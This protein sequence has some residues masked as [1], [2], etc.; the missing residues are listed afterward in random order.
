MIWQAILSVFLT[1]LIGE[2]LKMLLA[3]VRGTSIRL[4]QLGGM[5]SMHT[6]AVA[7]LMLSVYFETGISMLLVITVV[8]GL[9]VIRDA[10]GL[11]W[12][13]SL[14]SIA[15]NK[16]TKR[17]EHAIVGHTFYEALAGFAL[18]VSVT[19]IVYFLL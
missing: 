6:G 19:L 1:T 11:R 9:I 3:Y 18:G 4:M 14:H 5:P 13:M 12:E 16:L 7:S 10:T 17:K 8:F 15:L 2:L